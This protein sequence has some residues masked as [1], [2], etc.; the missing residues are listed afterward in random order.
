MLD[1]YTECGEGSVLLCILHIVCLLFVASPSSSARSAF[2]GREGQYVKGRRKWL[3][4]QVT[5][6]PR[7]LEPGCSPAKTLI[8]SAPNSSLSTIRAN[9]AHLPQ[10]MRLLMKLRKPCDLNCQFLYTRRLCLCVKCHILNY[11]VLFY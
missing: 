6:D 1:N 8:T 10:A 9:R 11:F 5:R 7:S 2:W 4:T 3:A